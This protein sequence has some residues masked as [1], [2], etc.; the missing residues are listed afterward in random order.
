MDYTA[1]QA[2]SVMANWAT[3]HE[4]LDRGLTQIDLAMDLR[5]A[6]DELPR[7]LR[8][9]VRR[10][11]E[12]GYQPATHGGRFIEP[13]TLIEQARQMGE[14]LEVREA[15]Q[16]MRT[17]KEVRACRT[18][19]VGMSGRR[20]RPAQRMEADRRLNG[21]ACARCGLGIVEKQM[22]FWDRDW[23]T[24]WHEVCG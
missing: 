1:E 3:I 23:G 14:Q 6:V 24:A 13:V 22:V 11:I 5:R 7:H 12:N 18:V 16:L 4:R 2:S 17:V 21:K 9:I 8:R 15:H 10:F 19:A 20:V